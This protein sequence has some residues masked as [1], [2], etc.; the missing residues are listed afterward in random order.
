MCC[1]KFIKD[2]A[3]RIASKVVTVRNGSTDVFIKSNG[4][5]DMSVRN[6]CNDVISRIVFTEMFERNTTEDGLSEMHSKMS[7]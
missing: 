5:K 6:A 3:L 1:K 4:S 2:V 7:L